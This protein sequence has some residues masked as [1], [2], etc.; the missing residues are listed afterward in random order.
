MHQNQLLFTELL[1]ILLPPTLFI[2]IV[3]SQLRYFSPRPSNEQRE[4]VGLEAAGEDARSLLVSA[5]HSLQQNTARWTKKKQTTSDTEATGHS[6]TMGGS[7]GEGGGPKLADSDIQEGALFKPGDKEEEEEE[8]TPSKWERV[9]RT[10][11]EVARHVGQWMW[12][13]ILELNLLFWRLMEIHLH[14]IIALVMFSIVISQLGAILMVVLI[15]MILTTPLRQLN[16]FFYPV[17]TVIVGCIVIAKM[18]YQVPIVTSEEF[19]MSSNSCKPLV[20]Y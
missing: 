17:F 15:M 4:G 16:T 10:T 12:K 7:K 11:S 2:A 13:Q 5:H 3:A 6:H 19:D 18:V 9:K 20:S 14:K 8:E 1:G